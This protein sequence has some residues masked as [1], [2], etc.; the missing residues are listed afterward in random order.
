MTSI[1]YDYVKFKKFTDN[2]FNAKE[3]DEFMMYF[4]GYT[5]FLTTLKE[6]HKDIKDVRMNLLVNYYYDNILNKK[7][8]FTKSDY[9][10]YYRKNIT[11]NFKL[12]LYKNNIIKEKSK[13]DNEDDDDIALHYKDYFSRHLNYQF[14]KS[15]EDDDTETIYSSKYNSFEDKYDTDKYSYDDNDIYDDYYEDYDDDDYYYEDKDY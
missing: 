14:K 9:V 13:E 6:Y 7:N 1:S 15:I 4:N 8:N 12:E 2:V 10:N 5:T 11:D 3:L